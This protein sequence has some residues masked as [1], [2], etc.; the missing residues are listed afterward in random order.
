MSD[1]A[2]WDPVMKVKLG[3][4]LIRLLLD[5]TTF[6]KPL[7]HGFAPPEPAFRYSRHMNKHN[8]TKAYGCISIHPELLRIAVQEEFSAT[9]AFIPASVSSARVQPMV[10]PPKDWKSINDGGYETVKVPFM[11]TRHCKVQTV[12]W[13]VIISISFRS[14]FL[15]SQSSTSIKTHRMHSIELTCHS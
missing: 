6:S 4:A 12:S 15:H 2:D 1:F 8:A 10:I 3:A 9:S 13:I 7:K 14:I 5:H 11:R